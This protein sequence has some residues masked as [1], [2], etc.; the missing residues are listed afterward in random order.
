LRNA[1]ID[2]YRRDR[3]NPVGPG[4]EEDDLH[5]EGARVH[6]PL[7]GDRELERL[8]AVVADDIERALAALSAD[9]RTLILLDVEG[10]T[11]TE[12][13]EVLGA[14]VEAVKSRLHRAR[15]RLR[16]RLRDYSP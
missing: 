14:S 3:S 16:A 4:Y 2:K 7:R 12:L 8:R 13:S 5:D 1:H 9:S 11:E 10:L 6:E 15:A